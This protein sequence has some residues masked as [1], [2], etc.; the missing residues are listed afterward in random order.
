[1]DILYVGCAYHASAQSNKWTNINVT[2]GTETEH[3]AT[4]GA[5]YQRSH[6]QIALAT[7][8]WVCAEISKQIIRMTM[9]TCM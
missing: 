4:E 7:P 1:M 6:T 5:D 9:C 8:P 3:P 2:I